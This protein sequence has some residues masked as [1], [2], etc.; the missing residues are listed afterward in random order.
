MNSMRRIA[1]AFAA[2]QFLAA[3]PPACYGARAGAFNSG[4]ALRDGAAAKVWRA[5]TPQTGGRRGRRRRADALLPGVW[6][7]KRVRFEVTEG[8]ASVEFDCAHATVEGRIVVDRAGRFSVAGTYVEE[9]GGPVRDDGSSAGG[10]PV[11]I[12]GRVGGSLMKL[13]ITRA[14]GTRTLVGTYDLT[15]D[16][17]A[18]IVK[19]R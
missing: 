6:G 15:R 7:G 16:R 10:Q 1:I 9:H 11:R 18:R 3:L 5:P 2:L 12:S 8:G 17:E 19:C 13:T 14:A 4:G